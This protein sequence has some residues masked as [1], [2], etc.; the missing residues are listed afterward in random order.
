MG[1]RHLTKVHF[2][3]KHFLR[4][5]ICVVTLS[6]SLTVNL[7]WKLCLDLSPDVPRLAPVN[8]LVLRPAQVWDDERRL[9]PV[10][11]LVVGN[12]QNVAVLL[13]GQI[14]ELG[15]SEAPFILQRWQQASEATQFSWHAR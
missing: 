6:H 5:S 1:P 12:K 13:G 2:L 4:L 11:A 7:D 15:Q 9:H 3:S 14:I 8:A 10:A